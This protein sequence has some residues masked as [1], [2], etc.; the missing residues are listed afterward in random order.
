MLYNFFYHFDVIIEMKG[1]QIYSTSLQPYYQ[2]MNIFLMRF[3]ILHQN[4]FFIMLLICFMPL[5]DSNLFLIIKRTLFR[6]QQQHYYKAGVMKY[7]QI[8]LKIFITYNKI[9]NLNG[10][11]LKTRSFYNLE[12]ILDESLLRRKS[13]ETRT[14]F[15]I[16]TTLEKQQQAT[17]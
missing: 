10:C 3:L 1:R 2:H 6:L 17:A 13:P 15:K 9:T 5:I 4:N 8:V 11:C 12:G 7:I 14:I 16:L